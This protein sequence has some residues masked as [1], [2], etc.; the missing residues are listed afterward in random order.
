MSALNSLKLVSAKRPQN[1]APILQR[2]NKLSNQIWEQMQLAR[3][4]SEGK[5]YAPSRLRSVKD[6]YTGERKTVEAVKRVRQWWFVADNGRVCLQVRYGT[7]VLELAKGK[8]SIEISNTSELFSVLETVK[9]C[10]ENG[11]LDSQIEAA[12]AAV[13]ERFTH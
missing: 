12:S 7:R 3:A 13:R 5:T 4:V 10:V 11:E 6:K 2:R 1:I 9:K 8:N